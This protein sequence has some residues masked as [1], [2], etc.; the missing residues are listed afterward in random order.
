[1][2]DKVHSRQSTIAWFCRDNQPGLNIVA[3]HN[4]DEIFRWQDRQTKG[5]C[6]ALILHPVPFVFNGVQI[7]TLM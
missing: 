5:L 3:F 1:M 7:Y 2:I 4:Q 6:T